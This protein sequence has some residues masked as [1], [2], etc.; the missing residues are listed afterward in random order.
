MPVAEVRRVHLAATNGD[1]GGGELM[2]LRTADAVRE[3]GHHPVVV[4][5]TGPGEVLEAATRAGHATVAIRADDRRHYARRLRAWDAVDRQGLLWCHGLL[6]ATATAGRPA[7]L[8]H[9]H[10]LPAGAAQRAA[11]RAARHRAL[12]VLVPSVDMAGRVPG[13]L[14]LPNWTP[15]V[16]PVGS[17]DAEHVT[18][19]FLGRLS[20]DKGLDVLAAALEQVTEVAGRPVRLVVA[21]DSRW[22]PTDQRRAVAEALGRLGERVRLLGHVPRE[23]FFGQVDVAVFP[24]TWPEPFGL[25]VAEAMSASV[26]VV[27]SDAG[28]LPEVAGPDHPWV[29][30]AGDASRLAEAVREAV[31]G[32]GRVVAAARDR[33]AREYAPDAG[34]ERVRA[35]LASLG[36]R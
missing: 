15:P 5:P 19:G 9:L 32:N 13:A 16:I 28:A 2:L 23:E 17:P 14:A 3:L 10:Q 29:A 24:S 18:V 11:L 27:V 1:L 30:G 33:W 4:A 12:A 7:R 35:V 22:V 6:P 25:V 21:G 26:P 20:R 34:R 31:T 36:F 8:A